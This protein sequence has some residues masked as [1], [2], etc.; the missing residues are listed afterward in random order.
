[1]FRWSSKNCTHN[2]GE[3]QITNNDDLTPFDA[4]SNNDDACNMTILLKYGAKVNRT[5]KI[6]QR[7]ALQRACETGSFNA[8][9]FLLSKNV[10]V[11]NTDIN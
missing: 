11:K 2:S 7:T 6:L 5:D 9:T 10:D 4:A 1:M 8:V 3:R